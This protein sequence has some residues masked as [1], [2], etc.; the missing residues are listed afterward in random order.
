MLRFMIVLSCLIVPVAVNAQERCL[1][2]SQHLRDC[3]PHSCQ[4]R[5]GSE[6]FMIR[7]KVIGKT[8]NGKCHYQQVTPI[9][10]MPIEATLDCLF[11]RATREKYA[12][13]MDYYLGHVSTDDD[14]VDIEQQFNKILAGNVCE[15][16]V[17]DTLL[18]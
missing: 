6:Q 18:P 2:L 11:D 9:K 16:I 3:T 14:I 7:H 15:V 10:D 17:P 4:A 13:I 5:Q 1:K 12:A 8:P